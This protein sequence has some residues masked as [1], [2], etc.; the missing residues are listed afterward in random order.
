MVVTVISN[1]KLATYIDDDDY[2]QNLNVSSK[3]MLLFIRAVQPPQHSFIV[4]VGDGFC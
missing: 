4:Q 2:D 1:S 3:F